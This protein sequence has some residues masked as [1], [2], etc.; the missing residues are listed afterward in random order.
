MLSNFVLWFHKVDNDKWDLDSYTKI[1]TLSS[2]E[3]LKY[4]LSVITDIT[5]GM[6]F[7]MKE[8]INPI[9]EDKHN[10]NGGFWKFKI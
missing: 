5:A 6:Y 2:Y 7:L 3:D 8:G 4:C 1:M 9:W 10:K